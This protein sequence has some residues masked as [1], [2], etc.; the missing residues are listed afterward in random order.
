MTEV[1]SFSLVLYSVLLKQQYLILQLK[2]TLRKLS[3]RSASLTS[4]SLALIFM[5]NLDLNF[6]KYGIVLQTNANYINSRKQ[7]KI[8]LYLNYDVA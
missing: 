4:I 8:L 3:K 7:T 1:F 6:L 5:L 2:I